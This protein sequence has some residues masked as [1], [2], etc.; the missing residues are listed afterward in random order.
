MNWS[1]SLSLLPFV[2]QSTA[3]SAVSPGFPQPLRFTPEGAPNKLRPVSIYPRVA[4]CLLS[5]Y[6]VH[7]VSPLP[8]S[9]VD[10]KLALNSGPHVDKA[11]SIAVSAFFLEWRFVLCRCERPPPHPNST[12]EDSR[13]RVTSQRRWR[14]HLCDPG[15]NKI[16]INCCHK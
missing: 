12:P 5:R 2:D 9:L 14:S 1:T 16:M 15:N 6:V 4:Q 8:L 13:R 7:A 11:S 10:C 3:K